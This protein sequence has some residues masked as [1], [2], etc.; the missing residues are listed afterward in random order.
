M[1]L[2]VLGSSA[3][4]FGDVL[5]AA[6]ATHRRLRDQLVTI[7]VATK[8]RSRWADD[9]GGSPSD[10]PTVILAFSGLRAAAAAAAVAEPAGQ[11][12]D[13]QDDD[14]DCEHVHL[15]SRIWVGVRISASTCWFA[16][17]R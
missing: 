1:P 11:Q 16:C 12:Q 13:E 15:P 7:I 17:G 10:R 14:D 3:R 4:E 9:S 8:I 2:R 6:T 5:R